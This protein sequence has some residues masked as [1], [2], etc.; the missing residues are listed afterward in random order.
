MPIML[1]YNS[2]EGISTFLGSYK[3]LHLYDTD[4]ARMIP[5]SLN[6]PNYVG[7]EVEAKDVA[8]SIRKFY[9]DGQK[10]SNKLLNEI[11]EL[12]SDYHYSMCT[13]LTAEVVSRM[14][15]KLVFDKAFPTIRLLIFYLFLLVRLSTSIDFHSM[16]H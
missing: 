5:R 14:H 7:N 9:F 1:G 16:E 12:Q 8:E 11:A 6:V 2:G 3:K 10:I 4:L 13:H 15:P